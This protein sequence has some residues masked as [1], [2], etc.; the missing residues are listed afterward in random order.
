MEKITKR[1][2][3]TALIN[4]ANTGVMSFNTEDGEVVMYGKARGSKNAGNALVTQINAC[5]GIDFTKPY[6]VGY[7]GLSDHIL[8]KYIEDQSAN[9]LIQ[10]IIQNILQEK[11]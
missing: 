3:Y 1:N 2:V 4:F 5:G 7:T 8:K 6:R 11:Y 10:I 9:R